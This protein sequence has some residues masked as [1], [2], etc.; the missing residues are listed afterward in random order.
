MSTVSSLITKKPLLPIITITKN[1]ATT[2]VF[3]YFT[4]TF[5]FRANFL[6]LTPPVDA[7]GGKFTLKLVSSDGSNTN[8]NTF[9]NNVSAGNEILFEIGKDDATKKKIMRGVIESVTISEQNKNSMV[10]EL[11]GPDWGSDI[12]KNRVISYQLVQKR[13]S[14]TTLDDTDSNVT[15]QQIVIDLLT[16]DRC[17]PLFNNGAATTTEDQ[18]ITVS[19]SNITPA[20]RRIS[21]F[22]ASYEF[23]D[24][25]L[26]T[27]DDMGDSIHYVDPDKSFIMK[28]V[29]VSG[30][31]LPTEILLTDDNTD[32]TATAWVATKV[33]LISLPSEY[34][35][36]LETHKRV[37]YG[38]SETEDIDQSSISITSQTQINANYIAQR[39]SPKFVNLD[40]V[41][42]WLSKVGTPPN[43]FILEIREDQSNLPTGD[44]LRTVRKD[45]TFLNDTGTTATETW[46]DIGEELDTARNY[47][48]V[49]LKT[50]DASNTFRWHHDNTDNNPATSATSS[51]DVTWALTTT[52]SRFN[53]SYRTYRIDPIL[54]SL[55]QANTSATSK[56]YH[57]ELIRKTAIKIRED[58]ETYLTQVSKTMFKQK[59]IL[60]VPVYAP[61]TLLL[62]GQTV[63]IRKQA[64]GKTVDDIFTLGNIEYL[65]E[66]SEEQGTGTFYYNIQATRFVDYT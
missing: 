51:D 8:A 5:D 54:A 48:I 29:I 34:K 20:T 42:L 41:S 7:I 38:I 15:I 28:Q 66:S 25:I 14:G 26:Q 39:F 27:L 64:S 52:P 23:L 35:S 32:A 1:D 13:T 60:S 30:T 47:W 55:T 45:K 22:T 65:F 17:Y 9:L 21:Q 36:T 50:G 43:D 57:E 62:P 16:K 19:A 58:M 2:Y 31:S 6:S 49:L 56:H 3:N 61:D 11:Q 37:L 18:G 59:E 12:L 24:D 33:G 46:F 4:S 44:V 40:K 63:R 10:I 53:Y